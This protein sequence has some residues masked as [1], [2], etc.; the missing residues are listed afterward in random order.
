MNNDTIDNFT[1][2]LYATSGQ[3]TPIANGLDARHNKVDQVVAWMG[4]RVEMRFYAPGARVPSVRQLAER[5]SVS[6]FTI[7]HAYD[8]LVAAGVLV[9]R[10]GSG[11]YVASTMSEKQAPLPNESTTKELTPSADPSHRC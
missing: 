3:A 7:V 4:E 1:N 10:A 5:L 9:S 6:R 2:P 8:K 11:F